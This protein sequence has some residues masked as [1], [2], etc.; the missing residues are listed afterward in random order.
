MD[1]AEGHPLAQPHPDHHGD[2]DE[3]AQ[4]K[5]EYV[6]V[7]GVESRIHRGP[8]EQDHEQR[9][10]HPHDNLRHRLGGQE[11][12]EPQ[13]DAEDGLRL[14]LEPRQGRPEMEGQQDSGSHH[15]GDKV[16][17]GR[18]GEPTSP[19]RG[20]HTAPGSAASGGSYRHEDS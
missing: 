16:A 3:G 6:A 18:G 1:D 4:D 13:E 12:D 19:G 7:E 14:R 8:V 17:H 2:Q 5:E 9:R 11:D 10:T 20:A 15:E